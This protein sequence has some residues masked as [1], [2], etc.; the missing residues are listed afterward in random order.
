MD[1][2]KQNED[3]INSMIN[4]FKD[5]KNNIESLEC[6]AESGAGMVKMKINGKKEIIEID[7]AD[8]LLNSESKE[9]LQDLIAAASKLANNK[10]D[11]EIKKHCDN[12]F[13]DLI[14]TNL[15]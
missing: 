13:K 5:T 2:S 7:I 1:F 14:P 3:I 8:E 10:M 9:I 12:S 11:N 15:F 6:V 4:K